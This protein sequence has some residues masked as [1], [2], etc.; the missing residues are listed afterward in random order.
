M[1]SKEYFTYLFKSKKY[2]LIFIVLIAFLNTF[3]TGNNYVGLTIQGFLSTVLTYLIP[4]NVFFF[5][6]DKKAVDTF[7]SI[8]VSRKAILFTGVVFCA[9][10]AY[11]PFMVTFS[12]YAFAEKLG[13]LMFVVSLLKI[14]LVAFALVVFNTCLYLIGNN[15]FD[16]VVMIGSYSIMPLVLLIALETFGD[17][18]VAG[19]GFDTSF[20]AYLSPVFISTDLF[21]DIMDAS[22][23]DISNVV[24]LVA[25]LLVFGYLLYR[26]YVDRAVER[27]GTPSNKFYSYP[28]VIYI[29]VFLMLF[30]ISSS[31]NYH[32]KSFGSF[33]SD[34]FTVY[35]MLFVVFVVAHFVYRRKLYFSYKLPLAFVLA[36]V[37]TLGFTTLARSTKGFGLS[38]KYDHNDKLAEYYLYSNYDGNIPYQIKEALSD[39]DGIDPYDP[40]LYAVVTANEKI[41]EHFTKKEIQDSTLALFEKY[42]EEGIKYFYTDYRNGQSTNLNITGSNGHYYYYGIK[43]SVSYEDLLEFAKDPIVKVTLNN[44]LGEFELLADGS[45]RVLTLYVNSVTYY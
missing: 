2:L 11:V 16:G 18:F 25:Y 29:Y 38:G 17:S 14:L 9:L 33:M 36:G 30:M 23:V 45:I 39:V 10:V 20:V 6:H 13:I 4:C 35:L 19:R 26:S 41:D 27:A 43:E 7:F 5:V 15:I 42:R 28:L 32:Y 3:G 21:F 8:P 22:M 34:M 37:L 1:F 24:A 44:S 12:Y 40:Y 31:Y